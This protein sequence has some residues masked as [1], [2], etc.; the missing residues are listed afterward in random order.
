MN[1]NLTKLSCLLRS[2]VVLLLAAERL[3][4]FLSSSVVLTFRQTFVVCWPGKH[5]HIRT[6]TGDVIPRSH[7]CS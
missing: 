7:L 2:A 3:L 1:N 6:H 4:L 5:T